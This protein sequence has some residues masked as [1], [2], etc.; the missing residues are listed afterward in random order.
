[1]ESIDSD[2]FKDTKAKTQAERKIKIA[3]KIE[4]AKQ[5]L[6]ERISSFEIL[7]GTAL[8]DVLNCEKE[9]PI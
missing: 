6:R 2:T 4:K 8:A 7:I 1:M 3:N 5:V 9:A